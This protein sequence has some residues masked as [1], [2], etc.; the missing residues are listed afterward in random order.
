MKLICAECNGPVNAVKNMFY[1][2]YTVEHC[3]KCLNRLAKELVGKEEL[4][5]SFIRGYNKA[6]EEAIEELGKLKNY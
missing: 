3:P 4:D 2:S 1:N 6:L 5:K